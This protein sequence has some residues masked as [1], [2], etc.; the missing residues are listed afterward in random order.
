MISVKNICKFT[1]KV[2][3][4]DYICGLNATSGIDLLSDKFL[5]VKNKFK[6]VNDGSLLYLKLTQ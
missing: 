5:E 1:V 3:W 4:K 6:K 2:M